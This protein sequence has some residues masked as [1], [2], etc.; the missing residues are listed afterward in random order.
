MGWNHLSIPK[1][2]RL[3][4]W[5]LG[6]DQWYH[7]SL[8]WLCYYLSMLGL[9]L[10]V[11]VKGNPCNVNGASSL[12]PLDVLRRCPIHR[13]WSMNRRR[14]PAVRCSS[15]SLSNLLQLTYMIEHCL[16]IHTVVYT[17]RIDGCIYVDEWKKMHWN[18]ISDCWYPHNVKSFI[19]QNYVRCVTY[20]LGKLGE[21]AAADY[22]LFGSPNFCDIYWRYP[23]QSISYFVDKFKKKQINIF[24]DVHTSLLKDGSYVVEINHCR[25]VL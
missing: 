6:I 18:L 9:N 8:Y 24:E 2:Q 11:L 14:T 3:H 19:S 7:P 5:S 21:Y 17:L 1:P 16:V 4:H 10:N 12:S 20:I 22:I 25:M 15:L 23:T 13:S